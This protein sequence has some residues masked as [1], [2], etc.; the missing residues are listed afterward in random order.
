MSTVPILAKYDGKVL[1]PE[2]PLDAQPG[3]VFQLVPQKTATTQEDWLAFLNNVEGTWPVREMG[4]P[5]D[6]PI[7]YPKPQTLEEWKEYIRRTAGAWAD[8]DKYEDPEE[9]PFDEEESA[10]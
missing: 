3:D 9:L 5:Y 1:V 6:P 7:V 2:T 8:F 4:E 10:A